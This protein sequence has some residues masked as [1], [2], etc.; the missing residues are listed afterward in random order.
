MNN[1]NPK[2]SSFTEDEIDIRKLLHILWDGKLFIAALTSVFSLTAVLYS[3]SL[4]NVYLSK[5]LLSP[6]D[7]SSSS[8]ALDNIGGLANLAGIEN[9]ILV[10]SGHSI[11]ESSSDAK[12]IIDSIKH[13]IN[14]IKFK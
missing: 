5:G 7:E 3:L 9:T 10:R 11:D 2:K 1:T 8:Q 12:F 6:V 13:S 4:P 14:L